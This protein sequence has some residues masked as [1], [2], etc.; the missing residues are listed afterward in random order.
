MAAL[1][2]AKK[3]K[4]KKLWYLRGAIGNDVWTK[5]YPEVTSRSGMY[6]A[7][8]SEFGL[9][10]T[11]NDT[12]IVFMLFNK[13]WNGTAWVEDFT[14]QLKRLRE[15]KQ[16]TQQMLADRSGLSVQTIAAL[17]Q[18]TRMPTWETVLKLSH[19]LEARVE[20]FRIDTKAMKWSD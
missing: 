1:I 5:E 17:E 18:G 4:G 19:A 3:V 7:L 13:T 14:I 9:P 6:D 2:H 16:L 15:A 12:D 8:R 20:D 10:N 11:T